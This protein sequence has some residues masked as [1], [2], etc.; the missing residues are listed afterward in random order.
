[1]EALIGDKLIIKEEH[2]RAAGQIAG[3]LLPLI[4]KSQ[5]K[6][7]ITIA[8]ESGAGKSEIASSLGGHL[9]KKGFPSL[10]LQQDDYFVYPPKTNAEMRRKNIGHVGSGEVHL[11]LIDG[12]LREILR[13]SLTVTKPLVLYEEDRITR[14]TISLKGISVVIVEGTYTT[15]LKQA[16]C[17][18]FIERT[19]KDTRGSRLERGREVQDAYLEKIL[20][21]EH[22]IISSHKKMAHILVTCDYHVIPNDES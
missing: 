18:V 21:I 12:N 6:Y 16:D 5:K 4:R 20:K 17:H 13:G 2:S 7:I 1:M 11:D 9:E 19:F 3:I 14:E 15:L 10:I 8:G 22:R